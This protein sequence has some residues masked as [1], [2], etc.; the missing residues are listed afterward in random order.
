MRR[1][2]RHLFTLCWAVSLLL[3]VATCVLWFVSAH[4][5][6]NHLPVLEARTG[7]GWGQASSVSQHLELAIVT[8]PGPTDWTYRYLGVNARTLDGHEFI[9]GT[10]AGHAPTS[11]GN[12]FVVIA[13]HWLVAAGSA[14]VF[15][16]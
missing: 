10:Y 5:G 3:C 13:P 14:C 2:A 11:K 9:L 12:C 6:R 8:R 16:A 7:S 15:L 4:V 1:L